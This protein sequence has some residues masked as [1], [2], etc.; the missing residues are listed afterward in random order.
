MNPISR[1]PRLFS[2][3]LKRRYPQSSR[4]VLARFLPWIA[5]IVATLGVVYL[6][7]V[8]EF[9]SGGALGM[10]KIWTAHGAAFLLFVMAVLFSGYI[11][12]WLKVKA[13][14]YDIRREHLHVRTGVI[15]KNESSLPLQFVTDVRLRSSFLLL[16]VGLRRLEV[17]TPSALGGERVTIEGLS[18]RTA[19]ALRE[20]LLESIQASRMHHMHIGD[21]RDEPA[22]ADRREAWSNPSSPSRIP[23]RRTA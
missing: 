7:E 6:S 3:N 1:G 18:P 16:L 12:V 23:F 10:P 13:Y 9:L 8:V 17:E 22:D 5:G 14:K 20:K 11:V 15:I 19:T 4:Y 2:V 21:E